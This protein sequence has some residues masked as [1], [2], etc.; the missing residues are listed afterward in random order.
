MT[1]K[2]NITLNSLAVKLA[3]TVNSPQQDKMVGSGTLYLNSNDQYDYVLTALHCILGI[4][5]F[6]SGTNTYQYQ[7]DQVTNIEILNNLSLEAN[8]QISRTE[9]VDSMTSVFIIPKHDAAIIKVPKSFGKQIGTV[10]KIA[11]HS[12]PRRSGTFLARGYPVRSTTVPVTLGNIKFISADETGMFE[13][14]TD[15][16]SGDGAHEAIKGYS[17]SGVFW[18][19]KPILVG[20]ISK[21][22]NDFALGGTLHVRD[23]SFIEIND[24]LQAKNLET[25][26]LIDNVNKVII[27][28]ETEELMYATSFIVNGI[29]LN[30]W[31]AVENTKS[32]IKDDWFPDPLRYKDV[33]RTDFICP[34]I[35]ETVKTHGQFKPGISAQHFIPKEG[36]TTRNA[37]QTPIVD[38]IV[39]KACTYLIAEA[40]Y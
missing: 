22:A 37:I 17:G 40:I 36:F 26:E 32:D 9:I 2:K 18:E 12:R 8:G 39:L 34:A 10:P 30:I 35:T 27:D 28:S 11:L 15:G 21:L 6:N 13:A 25:I 19:S 1:E 24:V 23:F 16:I 38:L 31:K 33:L 3:T 4:R 5:S 7:L 29:P 14:T 20:F